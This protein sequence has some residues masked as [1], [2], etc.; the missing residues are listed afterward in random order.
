[1]TGPVHPLITAVTVAI[2]EAGNGHNIRSRDLCV[3]LGRI[4]PEQ[5]GELTPES[6]ASLLRPL[7]VR[8]KGVRISGNPHSCK[9]YSV[10]DIAPDLWERH[11]QRTA[12]A[13]PTTAPFATDA[14]VAKVAAKF[15]DAPPTAHSEMLA[16]LL[17]SLGHDVDAPAKRRSVAVPDPCGVYVY[18]D[19]DQVVLYVGITRDDDA[20]HAAHMADK[21]WS[22]FAVSRA[23]WGAFT[24]RQEALDAEANLIDELDPPF[25]RT[26][27]GW[28]ADAVQYLA[29][30]RAYDLLAIRGLADRAEGIERVIS[31]LVDLGS[32]EHIV[33]LTP[34]GTPWQ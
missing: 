19:K 11:I 26:R 20:R 31:E 21:P 22:R 17:R 27:R 6:L 33:I 24:Y 23:E 4:D 29:A 34:G 10:K 18:Y 30:R 16:D 3:A 8:P 12:P 25:N 32:T 28:H 7:G 2:C 14:Y 5:W 15:A 1:V 13:V 9:G